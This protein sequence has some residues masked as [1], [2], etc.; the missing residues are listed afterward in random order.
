MSL[1]ENAS[2]QQT[3]NV[4]SQE[5]LA[6]NGISKMISCLEDKNSVKD[7]LF[8]LIQQG[9]PESVWFSNSGRLAANLTDRFLSLTDSE[10]AS[11]VEEATALLSE[12]ATYFS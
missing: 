5:K 1:F 10:N 7:L 4:E 6:P 3:L 2:L 12:S 9:K 11:E 8:R